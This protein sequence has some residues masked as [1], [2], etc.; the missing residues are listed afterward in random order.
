MIA[1][2]RDSRGRLRY[3][4]GAQVDVSGLAKEC[5]DLDGLQRM[6]SKRDEDE[7]EEEKKDDFQELSEMFNLAE[8]D[9]VKKH[10]GRLHREHVQEAEDTNASWHRPRLLLKEPSNDGKL[11]LEEG[12]APAKTIHG[13][14]SG[15]YTHVRKFPLHIPAPH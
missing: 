4:I 2:L 14:L 1:P 10:G 6:L 11:Q 3:Y 12:E 5:T 15:V 8:L 13:K 7:D 9:I